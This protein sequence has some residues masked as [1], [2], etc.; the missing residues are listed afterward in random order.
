MTL[1]AKISANYNVSA[2]PE[3]AKMPYVISVSLITLVAAARWYVLPQGRSYLYPLL[4]CAY[5]RI[6]R[7][8]RNFN[9]IYPFSPMT[10]TVIAAGTACVRILF[11]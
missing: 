7:K 4:L 2:A 1:A 8:S 10:L 9:V 6:I 11:T 5:Q 3:P